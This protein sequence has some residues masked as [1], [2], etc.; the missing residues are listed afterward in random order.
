[1]AGDLSGPIELSAPV[2]SITGSAAGIELGI[3]G[4]RKL[5]AAHALCTLP[6]SVLRNI[7]IEP[8][9]PP[10]QAD[11]IRQLGSQS[12]TQFYIGVNAPFWEQDGYPPSMFTDSLPGMVA[13]VRSSTDPETVTHLT[14]W[15]IGPE[16]DRLDG[17]SE[18]TAARAVIEAIEAIRPAARGKLEP[19]ASQSWGGDP[20]ARGA[21]AYFKP[22]Q[23]TRFAMQMG[24]SQ[25]RL[26]FCG[27]HLARASRGMEAALETAEIAVRQIV[28]AT[29]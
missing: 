9:L 19:I 2:E 29:R 28:S 15:V 1:M 6:F 11:A 27:E 8:A 17:L 22:G 13:A 24:E 4:G 7:A 10:A 20:Y 25:G 18:A 5:R 21:W 14:S 3:S 23:V 26:H 16:A 12:I